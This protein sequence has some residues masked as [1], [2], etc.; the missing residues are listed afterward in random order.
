MLPGFSVTSA[1][2][3]YVMAPGA[4]AGMDL[5]HRWEHP[6]VLDGEFHD[7]HGLGVAA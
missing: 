5:H 4:N 6:V 7:G 2:E 3:E 1:H